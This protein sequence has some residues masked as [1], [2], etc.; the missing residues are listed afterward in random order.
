MLVKVITNHKSFKY[1]I[2]TKKFIKY[3]VYQ[4][5]KLIKI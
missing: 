2:T 4:K 1:F 5:K 3:Q